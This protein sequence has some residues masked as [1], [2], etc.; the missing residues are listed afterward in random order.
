MSKLI[1]IITLVLIPYL[2]FAQTLE[3]D[4]YF[5]KK[6]EKPETVRKSLLKYQKKDDRGC[7]AILDRNLNKKIQ[8]SQGKKEYFSAY[9]VFYSLF[10]DQVAF[11]ENF[12]SSY[13][14]LFINEPQRYLYTLEQAEYI[15]LLLFEVNLLSGTPQFDS[16]LSFFYN[17]PKKYKLTLKQKNGLNHLVKELESTRGETIF[18]IINSRDGYA[19]VRNNPNKQAKIIRKLTNG[20]SIS[21]IGMPLGGWYKVKFNDGRIGYVHKSGVK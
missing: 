21:L 12:S 5:P 17:L 18:A 14:Q 7:I 6:N 2:S 10:P 11:R 16:M 9:M 4:C 15:E 1:A 13:Y 20:T 3:L 19:N 8:T